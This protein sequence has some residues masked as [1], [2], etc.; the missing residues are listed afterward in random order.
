MYYDQQIVDE[1]SANDHISYIKSHNPSHTIVESA[2][3]NSDFSTSKA[4]RHHEKGI[5]LYDR[6]R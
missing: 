3:M 1:R 2:K 5:Q 4:L 6:S